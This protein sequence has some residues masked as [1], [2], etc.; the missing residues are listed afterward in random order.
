M[1]AQLA[2]NVHL[3]RLRGPPGAGFVI[4]P[5]TPPAA[6]T[7]VPAMARDIVPPE[8][9]S[10][11]EV[12]RMIDRLLG[13]SAEPPAR[14]S[15]SVD[16]GGRFSWHHVPDP[17]AADLRAALDEA[18]S[19]RLEN[20]LTLLE[21]ADLTDLNVEAP[22]LAGSLAHAL[23]SDPGPWWKL[24]RERFVR[25][26]QSAR[27]LVD[28]GHPHQAL[29]ILFRQ[30]A[31]LHPLLPDRIQKRLAMGRLLSLSGTALDDASRYQESEAAYL[32]CLQI[33]DP[34]EDQH[35][36][37]RAQTLSNLGALH[38]LAGRFEE[39]SRLLDEAV[40]AFD[41]LPRTE[42][43]SY[44]LAAAVVNRGHSGN[45]RGRP[46][47]A[48]ADW[49]RAFELA[50]L[51]SVPHDA[52]AAEAAIHLASN[53]FDRGQWREALDAMRLGWRAALRAGDRARRAELVA[54]AA[55]AVLRS[56]QGLRARRLYA[57]ARARFGALAPDHL[58]DYLDALRGEAKALG[59]RLINRIQILTAASL[60]SAR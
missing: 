44:A 54:L 5:K 21:R 34:A 2:D 7:N 53:H 3:S 59:H 52:I 33:L 29:S 4:V 19:G 1:P 36:V 17:L 42:A 15:D 40:A 51:R 12:R 9:E 48:Q 45:H 13:D 11:G 57:L 6:A 16:I 41:V 46:V 38:H 47:A 24:A 23:G 18:G 27:Q 56:E 25:A 60:T 50:A 35:L 58:S 32:A 49:R 10:L 37:E 14:V 55:Q 39:S 20:A 8:I 22:L 43:S 26:F 31:L 28:R 30:A